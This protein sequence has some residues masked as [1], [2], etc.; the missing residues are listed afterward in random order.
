[1]YGS[2]GDPC[3]PP[4]IFF[5]AIFQH[6]IHLFGLSAFQRA[7]AGYFAL[8]LSRFVMF[9]VRLGFLVGSLVI[10]CSEVRPKRAFFQMRFRNLKWLQI[11][12]LRHLPHCH[13]I[14]TWIFV[15]NGVKKSFL[16]CS[17]RPTTTTTPTTTTYR[18]CSNRIFIVCM[19]WIDLMSPRLKISSSALPLAP[20]PDFPCSHRTL[21]PFVQH[22]P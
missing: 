20:A 16:T 18:C 12:V 10:L 5:C 11:L 3:H 13:I 21:T 22:Q 17:L 15:R 7:F 8:T 6:L 2:F 19:T 14:D 9:F 4:K 1:L